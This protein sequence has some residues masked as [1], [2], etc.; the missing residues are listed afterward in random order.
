MGRMVHTDRHRPSASF[1]ADGCA[2]DLDSGGQIAM[3]FEPKDSQARDLDSIMKDPNGAGEAASSNG[4]LPAFEAGIATRAFPCALFLE[5]ALA[6]K[7]LEGLIQ[8]A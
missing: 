1:L 3:L 8:I 6:K 7:V 5:P 2:S 4:F